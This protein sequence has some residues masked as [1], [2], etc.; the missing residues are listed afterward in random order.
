MFYHTAGGSQHTL[1]FKTSGQ[2]YATLS[3]T[4]L[5][6]HVLLA[7]WAKKNMQNESDRCGTRTHSLS[8]RRAARYHCAN[9]P[10]LMMNCEGSEQN[11]VYIALCQSASPGLHLFYSS[12]QRL[13][14]RAG[15]PLLGDM[16]IAAGCGVCSLR[17]FRPLLVLVSLFVVGAM[18]FQRTENNTNV[19]SEG[20]R[21]GKAIATRK[22]T[23]CAVVSVE[24]H[25]CDRRGTLVSRRHALE[26]RHF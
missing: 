6:H 15:R 5:R 21:G 16:R 3:R 4:N 23:R 1:S 8:L 2:K 7:V 11:I 13:S 14:R 20:G 26:P 10:G 25:S 19:N 12:S 22:C 9:R 17:C 18:M 24:G